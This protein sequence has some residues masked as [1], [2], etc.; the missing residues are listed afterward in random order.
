M[1]SGETVYGSNLPTIPTK[2]VDGRVWSDT[3]NRAPR[4]FRVH[5][6]E[7]RKHIE[8]KLSLWEVI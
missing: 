2:Y 4:I 7:Q 3:M 8:L 1:Q 5:I 6:E